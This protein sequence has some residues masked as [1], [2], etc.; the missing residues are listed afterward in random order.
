MTSQ[1]EEA[2]IR[3]KQNSILPNKV[4]Q[5]AG[6]MVLLC[7]VLGLTIPLKGEAIELFFP[8]VSIL[9]L[10]FARHLERSSKKDFAI[11]YSNRFE[12]PESGNINRIVHWDQVTSLRWIVGSSED[13]PRLMISTKEFETPLGS[14]AKNLSYLTAEDRLTFI[15]YVKRAA[16]DIPQERWPRFCMDVAVPLLKQFEQDKEEKVQEL[17][18]QRTLRE[19]ITLGSMKFIVSHPFLSGLLLPILML[20]TVPLLVSRKTCWTLAAVLTISSIINIRLIWGAWIEP[21]TTTVLATA[22]VFF[23]LGLFSLL[24]KLKTET[25]KLS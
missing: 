24:E 12:E 6:M 19:T 22:A 23:V 3:L 25:Q 14:I 15:R 9:I 4:Y 5:L 1:T 10:V 20:L 21:F 11:L 2:A 18:Q 13:S 16:A 8:T 17:P 7:C